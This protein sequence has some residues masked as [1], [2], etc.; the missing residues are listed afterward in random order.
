M[1]RK[2][3]PP[4][5]TDRHGHNSIDDF[6][7]APQRPKAIVELAGPDHP[8]HPVNHAKRAKEEAMRLQ[9]QLVNAALRAESVASNEEP[10]QSQTQ[11]GLVA[12]SVAPQP[13]AAQEEIDPTFDPNDA[14]HLS[15]PAREFFRRAKPQELHALHCTVCTHPLR[16]MIEE[17]FL[18]WISPDR[19]GRKYDLGW[20][21]I[22]RHAHA[23]GLYEQRYRNVRAS[24][25]HIIEYAGELSHA[26]R[27]VIRA[28]HHLA[29]INAKGQWIEPTKRVVLSTD[30]SG[31]PV[32]I[33]I[34]SERSEPR[35]DPK[36]P[37]RASKSRKQVTRK[38]R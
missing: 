30:R 1:W 18:H 13:L 14:F 10:N 32:K 35:G 27:D 34:P 8:D 37:R 19:I 23:T 33:D 21:C 7:L 9:S 26:P 3:N 15:K 38:T 11:T 22:Y 31:D 6:P 16:A 24:L 28:V 2:G 12:S 17:E 29:R 4:H 20:R 25:A 36:R 5:V